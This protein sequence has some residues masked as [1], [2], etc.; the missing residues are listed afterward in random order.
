MALE[1]EIRKPYFVELQEFVSRERENAD[2]YPPADVTFAALDRCD[3]GSVKVVILGQDPYHGV[4]QANG[5]CF[6]VGEGVKM[7]PSLRN[8]L[9]E[10][11]MET[12]MPS[13]S[14]DGDLSGWATQGVLL[15]N[16]VLTVRAHEAGSH[17]GYGWERFTDAIISAVSDLCNHVVFM[18][19]GNYA[20]GKERLIDSKKH[21]VLKAA[22]PSP[23][24]AY[25]GFFGCGHFVAA[26]KYLIENG[27]EAIRW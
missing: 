1:E 6:S 21:L 18:L 4:G 25:R 3:I 2:V 16:S 27:K 9:K 24:S 5:L 8:I 20:A 10:I 15:L 12:G 13:E 14:A 22:H 19:W 23:L 26:D 7:P 11:E 17:A